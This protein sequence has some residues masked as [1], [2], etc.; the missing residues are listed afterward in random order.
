L[1]AE[2]LNPCPCAGVR[3]AGEHPRPPDHGAHLHHRIEVVPTQ[4]LLRPSNSACPGRSRACP[5]RCDHVSVDVGCATS[6][7]TSRQQMRDEIGLSLLSL[8]SGLY[9]YCPLPELVSFRCT[10]NPA[11]G[12]AGWSW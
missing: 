10:A 1:L 6:L 9:S 7:D 8:R 4:T 2:Q 3:A 12:V 5:C 11:C